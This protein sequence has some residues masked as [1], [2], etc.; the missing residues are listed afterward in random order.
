MPLQPTH[1]PLSSQLL[2]GRPPLALPL[3]PPQPFHW[4]TWVAWIVM[5]LVMALVI[6]VWEVSTADP[7]NRFNKGAAAW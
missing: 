5:T 4:S 6:Y 1:T 7:A 3:P 2:R